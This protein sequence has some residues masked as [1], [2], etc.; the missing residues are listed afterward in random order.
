MFSA[1]RA[2]R[3]SAVAT[4]TQK[5]RPNRQVT[6]RA[7]SRSESAAI[8]FLVF[9]DNGGDYCWTILGS[10][11]E[12]LGR[13][14]PYATREDAADAARVVR[15]GAGAGRFELHAAPDGPVELMARRSAAVARDDSDAERWLDEG[16]S[17]SGG[18]VT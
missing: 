16:G 7:A 11:G 14:K 5:S 10:D 18:A 17:I 6:R 3:R 4:A 8:T 15:D 9:E 1:R 12:S 2:E 13:S